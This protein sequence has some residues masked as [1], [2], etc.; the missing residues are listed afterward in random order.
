[1]ILDV[2]TLLNN[3]LFENLDL[4]TLIETIDLDHCILGNYKKGAL[5]VQEGDPCN[6]VGF[7]LTG[8]LA[9][10]QFTSTGEVLT[11]NIFNA[12]DAFGTAL[13]SKPHAKYPFTLISLKD[14]QVLFLPFD[15]IQKLL[16]SSQQ[17]NDNFI[18]FL[19]GRV[20]NFKSKLQM[21]QHKDVRSRLI[22]Y[23]STEY[24]SCGQTTFR[25]PHSKIAIS[26]IIGVARPSVPRELRNMATDQIIEISGRTITLLKPEL[27]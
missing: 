5:I 14:S 15:Q 4:Q 27:F 23:L 1:M 11:I 19:S 20:L 6:S 9:I 21:M 26:E 25:L 12:H 16:R 2:K 22:Y 17:F 18:T 13:Y 24:K 7:V 8:G 3:P 10:Q